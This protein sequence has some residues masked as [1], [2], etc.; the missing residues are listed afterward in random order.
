L[1]L[2]VA[3]LVLFALPR[4][5]TETAKGGVSSVEI[6]RLSE[7]VL[8]WLS[9]RDVLLPN[10]ALRFFV[11]AKDPKDRYVLIGSVDGSSH[12]ARF[13]PADS[14]GCS[15][16]LPK[17]GEALDGSI[18]LDDAAGPERLVVVLSH[19]PLCWP[20]LTDA[21][22]RLALDDASSGVL[23]SENVHA[24]RLVFTKQQRAPR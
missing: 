4:A 11:K 10:D 2:G 7:G 9:G 14:A 1:A 20:A 21:V 22:T 23:R 19:E 13:Y 6:A 24:A 12:L 16:S 15:V 18:T 8:S 17:A 5:P 3:A